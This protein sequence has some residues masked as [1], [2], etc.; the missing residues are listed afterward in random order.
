MKNVL[1]TKI[2]LATENIKN[3][4]KKKKFLVVLRGRSCPIFNEETRI[5][6]NSNS[7]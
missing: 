3:K 7:T 2:K 5:Y 4:K 6:D 1:G